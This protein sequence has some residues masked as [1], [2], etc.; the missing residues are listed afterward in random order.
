MK[1]C[2]IP[3]IIS[4]EPRILRL[5]VCCSGF[6]LLPHLLIQLHL[7]QKPFLIVWLLLTLGALPYTVHCAVPNNKN[8]AKTK[9][10]MDTGL[11]L[12]N[13]G[14]KE[15]FVERFGNVVEHTQKVR[16]FI[17]A[18]WYLLFMSVG[19]RWV[20][21]AK[22]IF[23]LRFILRSFGFSHW[24]IFRIREGST[25]HIR[26]NWCQVYKYIYRLE[27]WKDTLTLLVVLQMQ[28]YS[29]LNLQGD[30]VHKRII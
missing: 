12:C 24:F 13:F 8:S 7:Q 10:K 20:D 16:H 25:Y 18:L 6:S 15:E 21:E 27:F 1:P 3:T 14:S 5:K 19:C 2:P 9:V 4:P 23:K 11:E 26:L 29:H 28:T 30:N 22:T 17:H